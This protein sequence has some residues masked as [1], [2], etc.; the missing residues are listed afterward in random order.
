[1]EQGLP[2]REK[3][4]RGLECCTDHYHRADCYGCYQEGPGFGFAC[5]ES[6]MRDALALLREQ[7]P[8]LLGLEEV[9]AI[10]LREAER[11]LSSKVEPVW[12]EQNEGGLTN[13]ALVLISWWYMEGVDEDETAFEFIAKHFGTDI[14]D[15]LNYLDYGKR[16]RAWTRKPSLEQRKEA[17]WK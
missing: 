1:M 12:L 11:I 5:R 10:A 4:I 17:A 15:T 6:L 3:I 7:E 16:W 13:L 9:K 2:D 14:D 8:R